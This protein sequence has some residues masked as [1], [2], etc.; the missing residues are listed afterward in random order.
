MAEY[1]FSSEVFI[2]ELF[3][4]AA[5]VIWKNPKKVSE[6]EDQQYLIDVDQYKLAIQGKLTFSLVHKFDKEVML[7][8]GLSEELSNQYSDDSTLIPAD[9]RDACT[10]RQAEYI[11]N[12]YVEHNNYYRMLNGQP[13]IEDTDFFYNKSYKDI[14]D[15]RTPIHLLDKSQLYELERTGYIDK[16]IEENPTKKYLQF[17]TDKKID[18]YTARVADDYSILWISNSKY[19]KMYTDFKEIYKSCRYMIT[20]VYYSKTLLNQN[21]EYDGFI[22]MMILYATINQMQY[23]FLDADISR[24]FYDED[25]IRLVY[26]SYKVPFYQAIPLEFHRKIVKN[27]NI[28]KSHKGSTKVF[29]DL[30]DIFEFE[31]INIFEFYMTKTHKFDKNGKPIFVKD[32]NGNYDLENMYDINFYKVRFGK[33]PM[34]ELMDSKNKV[35]YELLTTND[36][37]CFD[38]V[39]VR[40]KIYSEE[41]NYTKSKYVGIQTTFNLMKIL[42][43]TSYYLKMI[44]DNRETLAATYV[45]N[46]STH[47]NCNIFDIVI[48]TCALICNLHGF[49]GNIP[50]NLHEIG[51]IM[52]FNFKD[53]LITLKE[54]ITQD[55]YLK[56]DPKLLSYLESMSVYS[57]ESI[58]K[59]Y[60]KLNELRSYLLNK[61]L[62]TD[63]VNK[64]WAYYNLYNTIMYSEYAENVFKKSDGTPALSFE[65]LLDD[66]NPV[67]YTRLKTLD[68]AGK[69]FELSDALYMLKTS[70][71][72]LKNI[73]YSDNVNIDNIVE[74][75]F[76]LLDFFISAKTELTEYE[77]IYSLISKFENIIRLMDCLVTFYD[78]YSKDPLMSFNDLYDFILII[79]DLTR[80]KTEYEELTD[81]SMG[82]TD[83]FYYTDLFEWIDDTIK[84]ISVLIKDVFDEIEMD[85]TL[86]S[87]TKYTLPSD[88]F[89][90]GDSVKL[91]Y[92][93]VQEV[94]RFF[95]K[96]DFS[97][98]DAIIKIIDSMNLN[99]DS[100][101]IKYS[102]LMMLVVSKCKVESSYF[103]T[104]NIENII[105]TVFTNSYQ[106]LYDI[107][108]NI[109]ASQKISSDAP[110]NSTIDSE[111][112]LERE[113]PSEYHLNDDI[114][115]ELS[116]IELKNL[117]DMNT[118]T[119]KDAI[120]YQIFKYFV[121]SEAI[122]QSYLACRDEIKLKETSNY[123]HNDLIEKDMKNIFHFQS[124]NSI[125]DSIKLL[126]QEVINE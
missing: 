116:I 75:L 43:E 79:R 114:T 94:L 62:E 5:S 83:T 119:H 54:N 50:Y 91:L 84:K 123:S 4:L 51:K 33:D 74:Y 17:L 80:L 8:L 25:S 125:E 60:K 27:M 45:Y 11:I 97:L 30:F 101:K 39:D 21:Q 55:D 104:D 113:N 23:M 102:A 52:G 58:E 41:Y 111:T 121:S 47:S 77:V 56:N 32:E 26:D 20:N 1:T 96:D 36:P 37:Y 42:Y 12:H 70:C 65:D 46:N 14:S 18:I 64:Y 31:N 19:E 110:I 89:E 28:L 66:I 100:D 82:S 107:I 98:T 105:K 16:L 15:D 49:E 93:D 108:T 85:E 109:M 78:D 72:S 87:H 9:L 99:R 22:G 120:L 3:R 24:D 44:I 7:S 40:K 118:I 59:V 61:M 35:S 86:S 95:V 29:Y 63:D 38:D 103:T 88:E 92:D 53:D 67:M 13:D 73:Q 68:T 81:Q 124:T 90:F 34:I 57:L 10:Q 122:M 112:T 117:E 106:D 71:S 126:K 6:Y 69:Q 48:Y 115:D 2:K 76:K